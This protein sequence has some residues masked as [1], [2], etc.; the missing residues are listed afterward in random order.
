M[1]NDS[2]NYI[3][4]WLAVNAPRILNES[5]NPE[6][7]ENQLTALETAIGK[8]LPK[9][10][11]DLYRRYNGLKNGLNGEENL[12]SFFY[13]MSFLPLA[14]V[15]WW[16]EHQ[17]QHETEPVVPLDKAATALNPQNRQNPLWLRLGFD[18]SHTWLMI[19][20]DPSKLG[21]YGQVIFLDEEYET[22]FLVADSVAGLLA[23]F[24]QDLSMGLYQLNPDAAED[25]EDYIDPDASIDLVNWYSAERW[26]NAAEQ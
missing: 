11:K 24:A 7:T 22:A 20:L 19:D 2:L 9:D 21:T 13:G 26:Q 6:A 14:E 1:V 15:L 25:G 12:G 3:E 23:T 17:R 16:M 10:Y 18:G 5:L 4:Q 8:S